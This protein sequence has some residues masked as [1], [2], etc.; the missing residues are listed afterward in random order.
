MTIGV[1]LFGAILV[2]F[3]VFL[4]QGILLESE[5]FASSEVFAQAM[6]G[7]QMLD[8]VSIAILAG[9]FVS[10]MIMAS[11]I[12]AH[13]VYLV[14]SFIFL[15][16]SVFVSYVLSIVFTNMAGNSIVAGVFDRMFFS[17]IIGQNLHIFVAVIG[18][19]GMIAVYA[20]SNTDFRRGRGS[21][22]RA[23]VR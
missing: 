10:S 11:R 15:S 5:F 16:I 14:L 18:F 6:A 19:S 1:T 4:L 2:L 13:P 21:G 7:V 9:S 20:L 3:S 22:R 23:P 12:P 8:Y 17:S